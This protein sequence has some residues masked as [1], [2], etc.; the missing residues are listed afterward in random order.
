MVTPLCK[1]SFLGNG[2]AA[3]REKCLILG[4]NACGPVVI[5]VHGIWG[6]LD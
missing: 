6:A 1:A 5:Q 3:L 2:S 4:L